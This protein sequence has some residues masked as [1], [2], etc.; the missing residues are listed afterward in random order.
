MTKRKFQVGDRVRIKDSAVA[1]LRGTVGQEGKTIH[2]DYA[3]CLYTI[4]GLP[5]GLLWERVGE[6]L[7]LAVGE[8]QSGRELG[9]KS[10]NRYIYA[11]CE[12]CEGSLP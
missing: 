6:G 12:V 11:A 10:T 1:R 5:G 3:Q 4:E 2:Y 8:I 9:Y 7:I